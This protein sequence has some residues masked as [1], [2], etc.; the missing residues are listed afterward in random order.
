[1]P[2]YLQSLTS[3]VYLALLTQLPTL[4]ASAVS[5]DLTIKEKILQ[6]VRDACVTFSSGSSAVLCRSLPLVI[7]AVGRADSSHIVSQ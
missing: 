2:T 6:R 1:M 7:E 4:S 3:R 5:R